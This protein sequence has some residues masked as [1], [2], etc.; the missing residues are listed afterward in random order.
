[1]A[2][3]LG[4]LLVLPTTPAAPVWAADAVAPNPDPDLIARWEPCQP[5][6]GV[7]EVIDFQ[8]LGDKKVY[9]GCAAGPQATGLDA[10]HAA[11]FAT[12]GTDD[13]GDSVICRIDGLP[14]AADQSCRYMPPGSAYWS[15]WLSANPGGAWGY[16][17]FGVKSSESTSEKWPIQ[18]WSFGSGQMPRIGPMDARG[19]MAPTAVPATDSADAVGLATTWLVERLNRQI[20][21]GATGYATPLAKAPIAWRLLRSGVS[22]AELAPTLTE[23]RDGAVTIADPDWATSEA[24]FTTTRAADLIRTLAA[25]GQSQDEAEIDAVAD[26]LADSVGPADGTYPGVYPQTIDARSGRS[27]LAS[28]ASRNSFQ[29]A[30]ISALL[31]AGRQIP[32]VSAQIL[33]DNTCVGGAAAASC[34]VA[35]VE[36]LRALRAAGESALDSGSLDAAGITAALARAGAWAASK[37]E[38][39]GSVIRV[40]GKPA[41]VFDAAQVAL[42][43]AAAGDLPRARLSNRWVATLQLTPGTVGDNPG[44]TAIGMVAQTADLRDDAVVSG[45]LERLFGANDGP[46]T[47]LAIASW[48]A[49]PFVD[50]TLGTVTPTR[51]TS[52]PGQSAVT[53]GASVTAGTED[54]EV[55]YLVGVDEALHGTTTTIPA[56]TVAA[57]TT[58]DV[59][60]QTTALSPATTYYVRTITTA[61]GAPAWRGPI[62]SFTTPVAIQTGAKARIP[63]AVAYLTAAKQLIGG[64]HYETLPGSPDIGLTI[65]GAFALAAAGASGVHTGDAALRSMVSFVNARAASW[66]GAGTAYPIGGALGKLALLAEV[67]GQSPRS[68]GGVDLISALDGAVCA[69]VTT[70]PDTSCPAVGAYRYS[71]SVFSQSLGVM[72]QLR[73]ADTAGAGPAVEYLESLQQPGGAWSSLIPSGGDSD[74]DSTALAVMALDLVDTSTARAAVTKGI[75]WL[76][77][78][79]LDDGGFPGASGTS[80]NSTALAIQALNLEPAAYATAIVAGQQFLAAEQNADG[81]FDVAVGLKGSDVRASTQSLA[82]ALLTS[83]GTLSYKVPAAPVAVK[84]TPKAA[85][86]I[87]ITIKRRAVKA[88]KPLTVVGTVSPRTAA[89]VVTVQVKRGKVWRKVL[90]KRLSGGTVTVKVRLKTKGTYRLRLAYGGD[91][92]HKAATSAV[93]KVRVTR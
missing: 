79:Q 28:A 50:A 14:G 93:V 26:A 8:T 61:D 4:S 69:A 38:A 3:L 6:A 10:L 39:D 60:V 72:A 7:T 81:G 21:E 18:A 83:Y 9:V 32:A 90:A 42:I 41:F 27:Y 78:Q 13:Y 56:G 17:G 45:S 33:I 44:R 15:Y 37:Q 89:G 25:A 67:L 24:T 68:V 82:G 63:A 36:G 55:S 30:A 52:V 70:A 91:A 75:A 5:G 34:T 46:D 87:K 92:G 1:V 59:T 31:A 22:A 35:E 74:V 11:G 53:L 86:T 20:A 29:G 66:T 40:P 77:T 43:L 49:A 80:T 76:A 16:S 58:R 23:I 65:D 54:T 57:G 2:V 48:Q 19:P 12:V 84:P 51:M 73:A 85:S 88:R 47:A 62:S 71:P 64:A